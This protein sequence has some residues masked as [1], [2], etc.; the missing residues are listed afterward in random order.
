MKTSLPF[1]TLILMGFFCSATLT[2]WSQAIDLPFSEDFEGYED[3]EDFLDNSGWSTIDA[4]GD[5]HNWYHHY[6]DYD[7]I[8]VMLSES[9][10]GSNPLT[11]ENYL[12]TPQLNLPD[13]EGTSD[14]VLQYDVAATSSDFYAEKYKVVVST[15]G[16]DQADFTDDNIVF[17][18]TLTPDEGGWLFATRE[19][20][21]TDYAGEAV[22]LAIVHYDCTDQDRLIINNVSVEAE[23]EGSTLPFAENFNAY[24]DTDDFL[25]NS[26]WITVDA[27]NDGYN[28][29]LHVMDDTN[30]MASESWDGEPLEPENYLISPAISIPDLTDDMA[31]T[32]L[33]FDIAATGS[34]YYEE[35][36]KVVVSTTGND[37]SDFEDG[38]IL[39]E[40]T[41]GEEES[42]WNFSPRQLALADYAGETI[43]LAFVHFDCTDQDRLVINNVSV[44]KTNSAFL[45]PMAGIYNPM[46]PQDVTTGLFWKEATAITAIH[47]G[48]EELTPGEDYTTTDINDD[49]TELAF[50]AEYFEGAA[51]DMD[52]TISFDTGYDAEYTVKVTAVIEDASV[53][54][55]MVDYDPE[56]PQDVSTTI[57]W[58]SAAEVVSL[59]DGDNAL[60]PAHYEVTDDE[61]TI[62][63][64]YFDGMEP[65]YV[66][67]SVGFDLGDNA[68]LLVRVFDHSVHS[69][70]F[71]E[72]F[73]GHE[74]LGGFTPET[75]LPN[76]WLS[77]DADGDGH[78]WYYV[79]I[80][81]G[82]EVDFGRMQSRSAY[83]DEEEDDYVALTPDNWLFAPAIELDQITGEDQSIELSFRV[84]PGASS[85]GFRL[86]HYSVMLSYTDMDPES[87]DEIYS[88]TISE[89]HPQNELQERTVELSFYEGQQVYIAFRHHD[90]EDMDRLLLSDVKVEFLGETSV[91][92][93]TAAT[94]N[95]FPNP[96]ND[97][98]TIASGSTIEVV[99][100]F[101]IL[102]NLILDETVNTDRHELD[103][104]G[105]TEGTYIVRAI[106]GEGSLVR[107]IQVIR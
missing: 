30:V 29:Y 101:D 35:K 100:V 7:D 48:D 5:D 102:G 22:Y 9:W 67:L 83:F 2:G 34:N 19:V 41:L 10:D 55:G 81:D 36:Y 73:M 38:D 43:Y 53:S 65:G 106:T 95:V 90:V 51:A 87:F 49:M 15:T 12:I 26:D 54:P 8:H 79:P 14:I 56:D 28:W 60:D 57:H 75:W 52:F 74:A 92:E 40:E 16:N 82:E 66:H 89:D 31:A 107:R 58:G 64:S 91:S 13:T 84:A 62:M 3:T 68:D 20:M 50:M 78:N 86:E 27:N 46:D 44:Q 4:D 104:S 6:D 45:H 72:N 24:E 11:P 99:R 77:V 17:E 85:P 105:L 94:L 23:S 32:A 59:H 70:P 21:L 1:L 103:L 98:I 71:T 63:A 97:H 88:E 39:L 80:M 47:R 25:A 93:P 37:V 96:A 33:L 76:G 61:L 42:D 69:L 18:E